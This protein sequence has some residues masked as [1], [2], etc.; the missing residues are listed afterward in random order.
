MRPEPP[1]RDAYRR[2][3]PIG[4]RWSDNDIYGHLNN[5]VYYG[6]FDTAVNGWLIEQGLLLPGRSAIIGLVVSSGCDYFAELA[7]PEPVEAGLRVERIGTSS[8]AYGIGIFAT[9]AE[10][11]AASGRFVH[12]YVDAATRRPVPVPAPMRAALAALLAPG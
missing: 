5:V 1:R 6:L 12:V 7:F 10:R 4:T 3:R 8:V 9:G 11:A 2:F